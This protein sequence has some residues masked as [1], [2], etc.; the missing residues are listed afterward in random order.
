[1]DLQRHLREMPIILRYPST[2]SRQP[3]IINLTDVHVQFVDHT[4]QHRA[5]P[6]SPWPS[7]AIQ[8]YS[9]CHNH[10][11]IQMLLYCLRIFDVL[12]TCYTWPLACGACAGRCID[13]ITNH[14]NYFALRAIYP[15]YVEA[16]AGLIIHLWHRLCTYSSCY[17]GW[18][19][20]LL[21]LEGTTRRSDA[22]REFE[23]SWAQNAA[24]DKDFESNLSFTEASK[25]RTCHYAMT[26]E[27][28]CVYL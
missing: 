3:F 17:P 25:T 27:R 20:S 19:I 14:C 9:C 7:N 24:S 8:T 16:C 18:A 12:C 4:R 23:P 22:A 21:I 15:S 5:L 2:S 26:N 1:M 28:I 13:R 6:A 11:D 10:Y